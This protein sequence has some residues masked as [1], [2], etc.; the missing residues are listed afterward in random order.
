MT[1][2]LR[3]TIRSRLLTIF[4]VVLTLSLGMGVVVAANDAVHHEWEA[5][6]AGSN[7]HVIYCQGDDRSCGL[8]EHDENNVIPHIHV[9]H[10]SVVSLPAI[11]AQS[12]SGK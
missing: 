3:P 7:A 6:Q 1:R 8:P 11:G 9:A 4:C 12:R 10:A 5:A 2:P